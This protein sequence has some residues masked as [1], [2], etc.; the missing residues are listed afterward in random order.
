MENI[1][2]KPDRE[3]LVAELTAERFIKPTNFGKNEIYIVNH[4]NSPQLMQEIG[5]LREIAFR[6]AGGGTGKSLDIDSYDLG[7]NPFEQLIVWDPENLEIVGG[8]R[9]IRMKDLENDATG[10]VK[11]P[12]SKLFNLSPKFIKEYMPVTIELGRSFVQPDYQPSRNPRV[13]LFSL[14]NLW[15]GLGAIIKNNPDVEY[16]FGKITMYPDSNL[17]AREAIMYFLDRFFP[18]P[19]QLVYP[20]HPLEL[21]TDP[22]VFKAIFIHDDY[23]DNYKALQQFVRKQNESIPPLVNAYMNLSPTMKTF[24]TSI[25]PTFGYVEETGIMIRIADIYH[26]KKER[27]I[28]GS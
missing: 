24:G 3:L 27:H 4:L 17:L 19:D 2:S 22:A 12:T 21:K 7:N 5:R 1:I 23:A 10:Q 14:D 18:D 11:T 13:G 16:F 6:E 28:A 9:F 8:Y 25:N 26:E 15:D 20:H